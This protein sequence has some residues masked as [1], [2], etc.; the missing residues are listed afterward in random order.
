MKNPFRRNR[1]PHIS[2]LGIYGDAINELG[3]YRLRC[4]DCGRLIDGPVRTADDRKRLIDE[5]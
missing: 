4:H 5:K 2:V 3:G 1:C